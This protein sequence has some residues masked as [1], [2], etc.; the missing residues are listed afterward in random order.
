MKC[1]CSGM[2]LRCGLLERLPEDDVRRKQLAFQLS[3]NSLWN[4][5]KWFSRERNLLD[6]F[7]MFDHKHLLSP[8]L[9]AV[10][11]VFLSRVAVWWD[12]PS[13]DP[14]P[15]SH[16]NTLSQLK[17]P[18]HVFKHSFQGIYCWKPVIGVG[19][20]NLSRTEFMFLCF[21]YRL[22]IIFLSMYGVLCPL[23]LSLVHD[24]HLCFRL[25]KW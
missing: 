6:L 4:E 25:S 8:Y 15:T 11:S 17:M 18:Q 21:L 14:F 24:L 13:S 22:E 23:A 2:V 3:S 19:A 12:N 16:T 7:P 20:I 1:C 5:T 10:Q 9:C